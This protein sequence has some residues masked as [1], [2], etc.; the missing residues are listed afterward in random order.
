MAKGKKGKQP[1]AA[2]K[3]G[4]HGSDVSTA[5]AQPVAM[6][7][8][9]MVDNGVDMTGDP[10]KYRRE[11]E[12]SPINNPFEFLLLLFLVAHVLVQ[13]YNLNRNNAQRYN[14]YHILFTCTFFTKRW[15]WAALYP[16]WVGFDKVSFKLIFVSLIWMI[17][18]VLLL[19]TGFDLWVQHDIQT[20]LFLLYPF[21]FYYSLFGSPL[22]GGG[23]SWLDGK[24]RV[25]IIGAPGSA[26]Y[27]GA[28]PPASI[29]LKYRHTFKTIVYSSVEAGYYAGFLPVRFLLNQHAVF[30]ERICILVGLYVFANTGLLLV[31]N[32]LSSS[33]QPLSRQARSLGY[34]E[35]SQDARRRPGVWQS[36]MEY[37]KGEKIFHHNTTYVACGENTVRAEPGDLHSRLFYGFFRNPKQQ[38]EKLVMIQL[39][40]CGTQFL[41]LLFAKRTEAVVSW[42]AMLF[43]SYVILWRALAVRRKI[44]KNAGATK[45]T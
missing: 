31:L 14:V 2:G 1:G 20:F 18:L 27:S 35:A 28:E 16:S 17:P 11:P 44:I 45:G 32:T 42:A 23:V 12:A 24:P 7:A 25:S 37:A 4:D 34:W 36:G 29:I 33:A 38:S 3:K 15:G 26:A 30:N 22:S 39:G 41:C 10:T 8:G 40:V 43:F 13:N 6:P 19:K 21:C 5:V 9:T